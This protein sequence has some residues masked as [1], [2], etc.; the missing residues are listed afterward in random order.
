MGNAG[1]TFL[2]NISQIDLS[3]NKPE[4]E[5]KPMTST[6]TTQIYF[7]PTPQ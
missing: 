5:D 7:N 6:F 4:S 1:K 3:V 2:A